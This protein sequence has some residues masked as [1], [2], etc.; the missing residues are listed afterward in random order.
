MTDRNET[1]QLLEALEYRRVAALVAGDGAALDLLLHDGLVFSHTDGRVDDKPAYLARI[2]SGAVRYFDAVHVVRQVRVIADA[3]VVLAHLTMQAELADGLRQLNVV[4]LTV[5]A[6][7]EGRWQ[8]M[9][10]Q[11]TVVDVRPDDA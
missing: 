10:H 3:A 5:W 8:M 9:A 4:T 6:H 1:T 2:R 11:P 7:A